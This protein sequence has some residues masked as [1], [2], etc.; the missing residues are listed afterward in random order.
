MAHQMEGRGIQ[1]ALQ[2]E[3][4]M[5]D[6]LESVE[7]SLVTHRYAKS[8]VL[9]EGGLKEHGAVLPSKRDP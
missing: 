4:K 6:L 8:A 2:L 5:V 7:A 9:L 3:G 1:W